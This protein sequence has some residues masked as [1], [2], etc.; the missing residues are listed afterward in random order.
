M[1]TDEPHRLTAEAFLMEVQ[2]A[3]S[4][5]VMINAGTSNLELWT[6]T[7]EGGE[8][9]KYIGPDF[10]QMTGGEIES[11]LNDVRRVC[12]VPEVWTNRFYPNRIGEGL[13]EMIIEIPKEDPPPDKM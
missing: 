3:S 8:I 9:T 4:W 7:E 5:A 13:P 6:C 1:T 11:F 2:M 10:M 12:Q